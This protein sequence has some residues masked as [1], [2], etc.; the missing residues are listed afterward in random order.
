MMRNVL[1]LKKNQ[2]S[3]VFDFYFSSYSHFCSK[4]GQF[5]INFHDNSKNY[6][7]IRFSR[8]R[9]FYESGIKTE[10]TT[11]YPSWDRAFKDIWRAN[12]SLEY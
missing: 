12:K 11:A 7:F 1:N 10:V 2:I 4:N 9:N 8:L 3:D 6:F 5:A